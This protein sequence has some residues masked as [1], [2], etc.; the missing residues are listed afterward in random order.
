MRIAIIGSGVSGLVCAH[1]LHERH[2]VVLFEADDRPEGTRT[3]TVWS[4]PMPLRTSTPGSSST[5]SAL[6]RCSASFSIGSGL[7]P[8][9]AT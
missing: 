6:I 3:P 4:S 5:T 1:L 8:S 7:R 2:D 9:P